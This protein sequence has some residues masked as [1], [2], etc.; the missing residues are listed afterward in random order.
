MPSSILFDLSGHVATLTLNRPSKK[1]AVTGEMW[2]LITS[3]F[4]DLSTKTEARVVILRGAGE[5]FC[6]GAD[7]S[8]FAK[9]RRDT[10][11]ARS[12]EDDNDKA[13]AAIADCPLP[14]I[15]AIR[16]VCFGGGFGIA[17]AADLRLATPDA[18]FSVPAAKL[19]LAYPARAMADIVHALGGQMAKYLAFT[20]GRIDAPQ[21]KA[22]G[23]LLDLVD[24]GEIDQRAARLAAAI[25]ENA[26]LSV[27]ASKASIKAVLSGQ[28]D[29]F[30]RAKVLG[31]MTF[32]SS[33]YAEGRAAFADRRA[34]RFSGK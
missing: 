2:R 21:A 33:D 27:T 32:D 26:P 16:G 31:K 28:A 30:E 18:Q 5:D 9:L 25:A 19:G 12:Y 14:V 29:D 20:A 23:F 13:F 15:A 24:G 1:N 6:S 17:A 4:D 3:I 22:A 8:E 11:T 34:P 10:K 7:I